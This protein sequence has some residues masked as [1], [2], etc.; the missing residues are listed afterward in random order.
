MNRLLEY[1]RTNNIEYEVNADAKNLVSFKIG[2][3]VDIVIYPNK[4]SQIKGLIDILKQ[5]DIRYYI[6]GCGT[7]CYFSDNG[8][9]GAVIST[10]R[11][12][13]I[14]Y[15]DDGVICAECGALVKDCAELAYKQSLSGF[16]FAYGIP[17]NVG[18]CIYMNASAFNKEISFIVHKTEA[19]DTIS[20]EIIELSNEQ[21]RYE[22]KKSVFMKNKNLIIL[23]TYFKLHRGVKE[24]IRAEM[25]KNLRR[26]IDTQPLDY[27]SAGSVFKRPSIG[28]ASK[29]I[30]ELGLKGVTVGGAQVSDKHAG[31]IVNLDNA[32][33]YDVMTLVS[34]IKYKVKEKYNVSLEEEI[35][36]I[37]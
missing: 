1:L 33:S 24:N 2:G 7:N 10:V 23:K 32:T 36:Y 29:Y 12:N 31:F 4:I 20:G 15:K 34:I 16:E 5:S 18:G 25:D 26:R 27:P 9:R 28:Y 13:K 6:L 21:H 35:I 11:I 22:A 8:Y 3:I 17:G 19:L 37:E 14:S 30:D